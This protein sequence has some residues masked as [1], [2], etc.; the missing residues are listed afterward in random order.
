[1]L[2][3]ARAIAAVIGAFSIFAT[4]THAADAAL[5][6]AA[7]KEKELTWYTVQTIPQLVL[8]LVAGFEKKYGI[9]VNYI[10]ANST[11]VVLRV[12]NEAK[13]GRIQADV[14]D[15]TSML[16]LHKD[17]MLL[18]WIPDFTKKWAPEIADPKGY[19]VATN[20]FVNTIG[21]NTDLVPATAEPKTWDDLLDPK[22]RGKIAW[23]STTSTSAGPG[24]IG[25]MIKDMGLEKARAF[26]EKLAKQQIT[27]IPVAARQILDQVIAGEYAMGIMMFN[28]HAVISAAKGAPVKWLPMSPSAVTTNVASVLAAAPH[29]NAGKLFLDFMQSDEGQAIF[30]DND[31]LPTNPNV[32]ARVPELVPDGKRFTGLVFTGD[33]IELAM[34]GWAKMFNEIF[35]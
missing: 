33:E 19:W 12:M 14:V 29:P 27:A 11:E 13:A 21:I 28:H 31:Y 30:R 24:F 16:A 32:Q 3:I 35:R 20:Y 7:K 17:N 15:G 1:M 10:R 5:I 18:Q 6:E 25:L 23:G 9:K 26:L 8:P 2:T 22:W 4:S 34:P